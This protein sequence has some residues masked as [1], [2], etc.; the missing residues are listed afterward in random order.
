MGNGALDEWN[1]R[2]RDPP[3]FSTERYRA[4]FFPLLKRVSKLSWLGLLFE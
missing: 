4:T 3:F 1:S 2:S